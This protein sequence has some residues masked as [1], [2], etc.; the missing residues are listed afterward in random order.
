MPNLQDSGVLGSHQG[1][2]LGRQLLL[3]PDCGRPCMLS[4]SSTSLRGIFLCQCICHWVQ[5]TLPSTLSSSCDKKI[6][7]LL[8]VEES[9]ILLFITKDIKGDPRRRR[10]REGSSRSPRFLQ[11]SPPPPAVD[12]GVNVTSSQPTICKVH[13]LPSLLCLFALQ[14]VC[15][16]QARTWSTSKCNTLLVKGAREIVGGRG[17]R[18]P[19]EN[20]PYR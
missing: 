3:P 17:H 20:V 13:S 10:V 11:M 4:V 2:L 5:R 14:A 19:I 1:R 15:K 18:D 6:W 9:Q 7:Y 12:P 16:V 8:Q